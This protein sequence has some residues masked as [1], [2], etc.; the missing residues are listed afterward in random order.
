MPPPHPYGRQHLRRWLAATATLDPNPALDQYESG[1]DP[2]EAST[3]GTFNDTAMRTSRHDRRIIADADELLGQS[4]VANGIAL[5]EDHPAAF[6]NHP[7]GI[8][9]DG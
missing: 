3:S 4:V 5:I 6:D 7:I 9:P 1:D 8:D 2:K